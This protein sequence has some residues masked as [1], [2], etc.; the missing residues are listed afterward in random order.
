MINQTKRQ[1]V[2]LFEGF[3]SLLIHCYWFLSCNIQS[4]L[5]L[6]FGR[7]VFVFSQPTWR[8]KNSTLRPWRN[9]E[10]T[11]CTEMIPIWARPSS[12]F[13]SSPRSSRHFSKTWWVCC[14]GVFVCFLTC[15][16]NPRGQ[17]KIS[18]LSLIAVLPLSPCV[19]V[20][21]LT[22]THVAASLGFPVKQPEILQQQILY[23]LDLIQPGPTLLR[24]VCYQDQNREKENIDNLRSKIL[25]SVWFRCWPSHLYHLH[26]FFFF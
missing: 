7:P 9:L 16:W 3:H 13:L 4:G 21:S 23:E 5:T 6:F 17:R 19:C 12:S 26:T 22:N 25:R 20:S 24:W 11:V 15:A 8:T 10:R 14:T 1:S 2:V 18:I